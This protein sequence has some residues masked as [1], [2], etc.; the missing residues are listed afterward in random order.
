MAD[1]SAS[2]SK[3]RSA[4]ANTPPAGFVSLFNGKDLEGWKGL[5]HKNANERRKLKGDALADAQAAADENM[6]AHW[7]VVDAGPCCLWLE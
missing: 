7:S 4:Y 6:R 1:Y 2:P 5:A 3:P